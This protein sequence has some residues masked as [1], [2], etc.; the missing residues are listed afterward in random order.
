MAGTLPSWLHWIALGLRTSLGMIWMTWWPL[1]LGF[2]LAGLVQ[3]LVPR[4]GLR[5][6]LGHTDA[7]TVVEASALGALSS[8]CSYAASAMS[9]ALFARGASWTNSLVFMVASTN[10]VIE[11]G[12]VLWI[13]LGGPFLLAQLIGG[14]IMIAILPFALGAA[15]REARVRDM[16]RR[17]LQDAQPEAHAGASWR[18]RWRARESYVT[19]ARYTR[20]DL[21]MVSK[22]LVA[23]FVVAGFVSAHVPA[24]WWRDLFWSGHGAWT[25]AENVVLAPLLAALS[26]VCSV[27]NVPLAATLW[28][29]GVAFGA[30]IAFVFADLI[31]LPLLAI[32]RRFYG[33]RAAARML[34]VLWCTMSLAGAI[35]DVLFRGAGLVPHDHRVRALGGH[36]P[37]GATLVANVVAALVLATVWWLSRASSAALALDPVCGMGVDPANAAASL[38]VGRTTL[39]FCSPRCRDRYLRE[40]ASPLTVPGEPPGPAPRAVDPVCGMEVDP[41]SALAGVGVDGVTYYFCAEGCRATFLARATRDESSEQTG[42]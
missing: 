36:F 23:G 10:L 26:C 28:E 34:A 7:R 27:G 19:A 31:T 14:V 25:V 12:V 16:R 18:E 37:L 13:V 11:L 38:V 4:D 22:E 24:A 39:Y 9:R 3:S 15:F 41:R 2:C 42:P 21:T 5:A 17:V 40:G 35:V 32:Y 29:H 33:T 20:G 30:V 1:V 8:S 6:R